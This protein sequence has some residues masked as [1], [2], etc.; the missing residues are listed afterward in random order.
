MIE[1]AEG[2]MSWY[3]LAL[4]TAIFLALRVLLARRRMDATA[5]TFL[6]VPFN[7]VSF[8]L[9]RA[10]SFRRGAPVLPN[11]SKD[12]LFDA[13]ADPTTRAALRAGEARLSQ[14]F[15]LAAL[16]A[17]STRDTYRENLYILAALE[18]TVSPHA[19]SLARR[20]EAAVL[21]AVDVG[22]KDFSYATALERWLR[23]CAGEQ[24]RVSL[25]G[26]ELDGHP[27][28]RDGYS[29]ADHAEAHARL[30]GNPEVRYRVQDFLACDETELDV[31]FFFFPF[32]LRYAL[33]RWGLPLG[34]FA[35]ERLFQ[36]AAASLRDGGLLVIMNHTH[37]ERD[38]QAALLEQIGSLEVL[39]RAPVDGVWL[40]YGA[41]VPERT[42][43]VARK[44][45]MPS[46]RVSG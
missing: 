31:V 28:Y 11:E 22:S 43:T 16:A 42:L 7:A 32:V 2:A 35:P 6:K 20:A 19:S 15:D 27:I 46:V 33:V 38:R 5:L 13:V 21:R 36:H 45:A 18:R 14:R 39:E 3:W 4:A 26:I 25:L 37:E 10:L 44:R 8:R 24:A 34:H 9:R 17:C 41:D 29:R 30:T 12:G 23:A 40:D 1:E